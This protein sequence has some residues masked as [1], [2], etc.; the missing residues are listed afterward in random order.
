MLVLRKIGHY[1]PVT[2]SELVD[3]LEELMPPEKLM[4]RFRV[5]VNRRPHRYPLRDGMSLDDRLRVGARILVHERMN[6]LRL[7]GYIY[8]THFKA[9]GKRLWMITE[10][11]QSVL[12]DHAKGL[13]DGEVS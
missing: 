9:P 3:V 13:N 5:Y 7:K 11:G 1:G 6:H 12:D 10:T 8:W 2:P 4:A